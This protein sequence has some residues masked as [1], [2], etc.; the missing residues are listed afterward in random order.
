MVLML[1][2]SRPDSRIAS[3]NKLGVGEGGRWVV[4]GGLLYGLKGLLPSQRGPEFSS[5]HQFQA[6]HNQQ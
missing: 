4:L 3:E 5:Q 1:V 2:Y 6:A